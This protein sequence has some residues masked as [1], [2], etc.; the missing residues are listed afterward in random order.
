VL[1]PADFRVVHVQAVAFTHNNRVRHSRVLSLLLHGFGHRYN[2]D[3]QAGQ[4]LKVPGPIEA[5]IKINCPLALA[6][7]DGRWKFIV[8]D[9]RV[10]SIWSQED[11]S[12]QDVRDIVAG[13]VQPLLAFPF[14]DEIQVGRLALVVR[15]RALVTNPAVELVNHFCKESLSSQIDPSAPLR[16]SRDFQIHN[17]KRFTLDTGTEVNSWV[18]C[19][20]VR[21][22]IGVEHDINTLVED[23]PTAKFTADTASAFYDQASCE[24]NKILALYF[25]GT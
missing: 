24:L 21:N 20:S 15:R 9:E 3:V 19:K 1:E 23:V 13:C 8:A 7:D 16:H 25:P 17:L 22:G 12:T 4:V 10:D 2:G 6:S 18:R 14:S 5:E 11:G